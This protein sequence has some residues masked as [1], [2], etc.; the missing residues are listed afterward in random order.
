MQGLG[1]SQ[2]ENLAF[3]ASPANEV[4][5][6]STTPESTNPEERW[7]RPCRLAVDEVAV[8]DHVAEKSPVTLRPQLDPPSE[9]V[10]LPIVGLGG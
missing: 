2:P 10:K 5:A 6:E 9:T 8:S 7:N 1:G 4:E 3:M